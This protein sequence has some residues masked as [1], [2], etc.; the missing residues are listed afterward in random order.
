MINSV[1][2]TEEQQTASAETLLNLLEACAQIQQYSAPRNCNTD[3]LPCGLIC[4]VHYL[5][6]YK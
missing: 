5:A 1:S 6:L 3:I 4:P 2:F